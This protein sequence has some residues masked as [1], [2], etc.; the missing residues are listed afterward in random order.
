MADMGGEGRGE[1]M[2]EMG[3]CVM[4]YLCTVNIVNLDKHLISAISTPPPP[5]GVEIKSID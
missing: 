1:Y 3:L 4:L 2:R 5:L